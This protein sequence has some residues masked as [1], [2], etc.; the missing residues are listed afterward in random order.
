MKTTLKIITNKNLSKSEKDTINKA[1]LKEWGKDELKDFN[2]D[3]EPETLWFF[4]KRGKKIVSLG[5][6]RPIK[7][8]YQGKTY[9]IGGICSTISIEKRKGYGTIMVSYMTDYAKKT[10][11][12]LLGFT[13]KKNLKFFS[14][15]GLG[16]KVDFIKRF[17]YINP[18]TK[19]KIYDSQGNGIY[20]EGKDKFISK[21]L[22][23]KSKVYIDV[24][25][26]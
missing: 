16:T 3:Y 2:K 19:E 9:N 4:V 15:A 11:K 23:T 22:S 20:F 6:I 12:T 5:G 26:W 1:R 21:V 17:V 14:R 7:I 10:G 24:L 18:K 25:H 8:N 13:S